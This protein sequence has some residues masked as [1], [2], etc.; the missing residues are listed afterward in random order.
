MLLMIKLRL[1]CGKNWSLYEQKAA[2]NKASVIKQLAKLEYRNGSSV[3]EH[4]NFFQGHI[5]QLTIMKINL[6]DEVQALLLL[7][8]LLDS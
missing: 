8:S 3:I 5:N 4:L 1:S 7:S 2:V 6:D